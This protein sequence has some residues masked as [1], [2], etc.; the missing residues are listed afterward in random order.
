MREQITS[1]EINNSEFDNSLADI[2]KEIDKIIL[3]FKLEQKNH[4]IS[5][6]VEEEN[7]LPLSTKKNMY[8]YRFSFTFV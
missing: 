4:D 5:E 2:K 7:N 6:K 8:G 3:S 1:S